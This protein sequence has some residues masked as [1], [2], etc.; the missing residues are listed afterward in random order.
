MGV[1]NTHAG[2]ID[3]TYFVTALIYTTQKAKRFICP[4][5]A[6][7][8][9]KVDDIGTRKRSLFSKKQRGCRSLFL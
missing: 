3:S 2:H 1:T 6:T 7:N 8:K 9:S 4:A 5:Y